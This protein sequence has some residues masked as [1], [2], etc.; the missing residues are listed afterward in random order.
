MAIDLTSL[1]T[2][3][4]FSFSNPDVLL[5]ALTHPSFAY[6]HG[7]RLADNQ[8]LEFLGDA[9][10]QLVASDFFYRR[11]PD[12]PE[13]Q[14][15]KMRAG[16]VCE[17]TL[18]RVAEDLDLGPFLRLGHGESMTGGRENPSNLSDAVEAVLAA[19]YLDGGWEAALRVGQKL[20]APYLELAVDGKLTYDHKSR[21]YEWA[22]AQSDIAIDFEV[23]EALGPTHDRM[24]VVGLIIDG[25]VR[26][27]GRGRTK[28][29]AEQNASRAFLEDIL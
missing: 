13:G 15:T 26:A 28:K 5:E 23:L 4:G 17:Q 22:Q 2:R 9:V 12:A 25:V 19:V 16:V 27:K 7:E 10:L 20:L 29:A 11:C 14:M 24:F 1:E 18:T 8:R 6:E 3:L 21:L